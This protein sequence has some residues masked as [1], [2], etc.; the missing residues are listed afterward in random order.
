MLTE[1][2][3]ALTRS[4][5]CSIV[6]SQRRQLNNNGLIVSGRLVDREVSEQIRLSEGF[7]LFYHTYLVLSK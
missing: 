5:T 1:V 4:S 6:L 3:K 2:I 7:R